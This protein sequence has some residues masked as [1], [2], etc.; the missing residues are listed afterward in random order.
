MKP[1]LLVITFFASV[2]ITLSVA[3]Y[4]GDNYSDIIGP[5][6]M[7]GLVAILIRGLVRS[8]KKGN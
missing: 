4:I 6:I 7:L 5:A 8:I 3:N 2:I 1:A